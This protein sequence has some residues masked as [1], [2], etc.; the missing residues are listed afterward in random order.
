MQTLTHLEH[1]IDKLY[2]L[3]YTEL[4][5]SLNAVNHGINYLMVRYWLHSAIFSL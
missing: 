2:T 5:T 3:Q 4:V 1:S